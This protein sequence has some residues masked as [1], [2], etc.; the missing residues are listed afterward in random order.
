[1]DAGAP[2]R[3]AS[4]SELKFD[5]SKYQKVTLDQ[6]EVKQLADNYE[7]TE[8]DLPPYVQKPAPCLH[9]FRFLRRKVEHE[10]A[11]NV[12]NEPN[13]APMWQMRDRYVADVF[14][15]TKCLAKRE[16]PA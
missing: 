11:V 1:M 9:D 15:C 5:P 3:K 6:G 16:V 12:Q 13:G 7:R 8:D 4:M 10:G 2:T 14:F